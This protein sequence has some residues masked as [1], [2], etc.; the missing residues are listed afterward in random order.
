MSATNGSAVSFR[1][2]IGCCMVLALVASALFASSAS[3]AKTPLNPTAYVA[4]GDSISFGYKEETFNDNYPTES[5]SA[6]EPGFVGIVG[7]KLAAPEKKAG[8]A[9]ATIDLACPGETSGGLIGNGPLG[10]SLEEERAAKS[11]APLHVSAPCAYHNVDGFTLKT[12][13]GSVSEL[14][15]AVGLLE[16]GVQVKAVTLNIGSN[17]E[18][19]TVGKCENPAYD[20]EQGYTGGLFECITK[21]AGP[22]GHEYPG[23]LFY[24]IITNVGEAIGVL[25]HYGY[26]GPVSVLGFYNP[27]AEILPGSDALQLKLNEA[28]EGE[29]HAEAF[30]PGVVYAN[31]FPVFNPQKSKAEQADICKFTE[32][33]NAKDKKVNF[34]KYLEAK[35]YSH[36]E[37]EAIAT[38]EASEKYPEG[39]IHPTALGYAKL[40][41]IVLKAGI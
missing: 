22:E 1:R 12:E 11:E 28:F 6:F 34:E 31:P 27:Q 2:L 40:A 25:R 9:L 8:N 36:A 15:Y 13:Q 33:C 30:G 19:E 35:G 29:I 18:L 23:G 14:E 16:S 17:D 38:P 3:A 37:A 4:L 21:E 7:K 10:T 39:D 5:P 20:E 41:S 32:E 26:T 24:H